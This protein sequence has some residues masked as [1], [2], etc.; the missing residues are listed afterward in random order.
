[1][2]QYEVLYWSMACVVATALAGGAACSRLPSLRGSLFGTLA[3]SAL[4][5]CVAYAL[6]RTGLFADHAPIL[7]IA[8]FMFCMM[9]SSA[10]ALVTRRLFRRR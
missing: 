9:I 5:G 1:M 7:A 2:Q 10:A 6:A 8:A 4:V 3:L